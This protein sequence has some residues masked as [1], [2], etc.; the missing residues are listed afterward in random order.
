MPL[1]SI[2]SGTMEVLSSIFDYEL[3]DVTLHRAGV[4]VAIV[5]LTLI[6]RRFAVLAVL[7]RLRAFTLR[8]RVSWDEA[9]VD[10]TEVPLRWLITLYG[11]WLAVWLLSAPMD[12]PRLNEVLEDAGQLIFL[13]VGAW[14]LFR[15]VDVAQTLLKRRAQD[16]N[17]WVEASV[18]PL[19][20]SS[21]RIVVVIISGLVIAQN[22]GY[23][24]GGLIASL[25]LGGAAVALA[26][27][28]TIA[29]LFGSFMILVDKPFR[30]GHWIKGDGFEGIVEEIGFRSTRL[31]TFAQTVESIPNNLLANVRVENVDRRRDPGLNVR[32]VEM[33][34]GVTYRT[35]AD[36]MERAL[37][38]I[39]EILRS[40]D[41]VD[42][43]LFQLVAFTGFG[44]SS[45][46]IYLYYFS[47]R[48]D[49]EYHLAVRERV[50]LKIMRAL[51]ELGLQIAFPTRSIYLEQ[52]PP[53]LA[54]ADGEERA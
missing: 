10:A 25:G 32:R 44:E 42:Q 22:L 12:L 35:T 47:N 4:S 36:E 17:D 3:Y 45:L 5:F 18:V 19:L 6:L 26:S 29:N 13:F 16:P 11:M 21:L 9:L 20:V 41:G 38:R 46:D 33:T 30:A 43:K 2:R 24:V 37:E 7:R 15:M 27:R 52:V 34:V 50:N 49:W 48:A 8:T 14:W 23:S 28:D 1:L 40:D 39:R 54:R 31:R 51:A 53:G